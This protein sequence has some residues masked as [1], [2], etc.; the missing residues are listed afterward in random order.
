MAHSRTVRRRLAKGW[1]L[2]AATNTPPAVLRHDLT[3]QRFSRL[4]AMAYAHTLKGRAYW[5]CRCDCGGSHTVAAIHLKNGLIQS[6]GCLK[7]ERTQARSLKHGQAHT[8]TYGAWCSMKARCQQPQHKNYAAYGGRGITVCERW[9]QSFQAF[10]DDM[11]TRPAGYTLDRRDNDKGYSPENCRWATRL[12]QTS[13]RRNTR[14]VI[15]TGKRMPV[16]E[17]ARITGL[18]AEAIWLKFTK[19][20]DAYGNPCVPSLTCQ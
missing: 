12:E 6:C 15:L 18:H 5:V 10:L 4:I 9:S 3:G 20:L 14:F 16:S 1:T 8:S 7:R 13:N 19:G 11:G 2:E 17:A